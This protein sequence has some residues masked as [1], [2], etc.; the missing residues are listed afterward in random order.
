MP[1][2]MMN[3]FGDLWL[4][5]ALILTRARQLT[6]TLTDPIRVPRTIRSINIHNQLFPFLFALNEPHANPKRVPSSLVNRNQEPRQ[7]LHP[8]VQCALPPVLPPVNQRQSAIAQQLPPK[9]SSTQFR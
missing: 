4:C 7:M 3:L 5:R 9:S 8:L 1:T 2:S 6:N